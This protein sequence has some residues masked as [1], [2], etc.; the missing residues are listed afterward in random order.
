MRCSRGSSRLVAVQA[1]PRKEVAPDDAFL[2]E[3]FQKK[4]FLLKTEQSPAEMFQ[5]SVS[6]GGNTTPDVVMR[7]GDT[8]ICF[9]SRVSGNFGGNSLVAAHRL[10]TGIAHTCLTSFFHGGPDEQSMWKLGGCQWEENSLQAEAICTPA[11]AFLL[12]PDGSIFY[13]THNP[14]AEIRLPGNTRC[15]GT[16]TADL[17]TYPAVSFLSVVKGYFGG[18]GE[19]AE[20]LYDPQTRGVS[21]VKVQTESCDQPDVEA[22]GRSLFAGPSNLTQITPRRGIY[23]VSGSNGSSQTKQMIRTRDGVCYLTKVSGSLDGA[24]ERIRIFP[25]K[26]AAGVEYWFVEARSQSGGSAYG[27]SE[28][29]MYDQRWIELN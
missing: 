26:D 4:G 11:S 3:D 18:G 13:T 1:R 20:I 14:E 16:D 10:N 25:K 29:V 28:C 17:W 5:W 21:K 22:V 2:D 6:P 23:S 12:D 7:S 9:L 8:H 27:S 19:R 24:G 15:S